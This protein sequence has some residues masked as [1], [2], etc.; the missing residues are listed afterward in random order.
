MSTKPTCPNCGN[1]EMDSFFSAPNVPVHSVVLLK[2]RQEAIDFPTGDIELAFCRSCGFVSN[3]AFD[4]DLQ[5]YSHEYESTQQYSPTFNSFHSKLAEGLVERYGL[6]G[7]QVVEIGCGQGEFLALLCEAGADKGIGFD[8]AF[9]A[10]RNEAVDGETISIVK[11]Y[12]SEQYTGTKGD[13]YCC[14]MT[15]EHIGATHE[16]VS[17]VRRAIADQTDSIVFFQVPDARRVLRDLG[18]W[19][20]YY[21]HCS[22]FS[23]PSLG[24]LFRDCGFDVLDLSTDY[25]DQYLMVEARPATGA[26]ASLPP[27][28]EDLEGITKDVEYFAS[29]WKAKVDGWRQTLAQMKADNRR[30]VIWGGGSKGVAFLTTLGITDEIAYAVDINPLKHGTFMAGTGQEVVSPEFLRDYDPKAVIVMNPIYIPEIGEQ[31]RDMGIDAE[32]LTP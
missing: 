9:V 12:Y 8:P 13:F 2:T 3:V 4:A 1:A 11:D 29:N 25:D 14:K 32:L 23:P 7:K 30:P 5:D 6:C 20:I 22:Y 28:G 15:L 24:R 19:D 31:L 10:G 17:T 27:E 26:P 21:E 18:F 16:F